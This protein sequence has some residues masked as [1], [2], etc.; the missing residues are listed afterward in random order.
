MR[1]A[2]LHAPERERIRMNDIILIGM[3]GSGKSTAGVLAAKASCKSFVDT[4]LLI[5]QAEGA[6][7]QALLESGGYEAFLA[8]EERVL[9]GVREENAVIATG[10]SAVYSEA[11]MAH[12]KTLGRT[13]YLHLSFEE[14][15]RRLGDIR[16]RGIVFREG[17]DLRQMY[18]D[19]LSLYKRYA[20]VMIDCCGKTVEQT[21]ADILSALG[22]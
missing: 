17:Q 21:V 11:G 7:L 5:Q 8:C 18:D 6:S 10:G 22:L 13:V 20:D 3:P 15:A 19:R 16:T 4:D 1:K 2:A 9:L 12:L 14:M